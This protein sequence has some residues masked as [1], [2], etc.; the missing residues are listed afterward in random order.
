M[1]VE[2]GGEGAGKCGG[3]AP[4]N[5]VEGLKEE[6]ERWGWRWVMEVL[7]GRRALGRGSDLEGS[8]LEEREA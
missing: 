3:A 8:L 5:W 6:E 7:L 4:P 2:V 1:E